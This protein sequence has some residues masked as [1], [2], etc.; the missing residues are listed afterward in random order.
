MF[1]EETLLEQVDRQI[2]KHLRQDAHVDKNLASPDS[3][4][5]RVIA[6]QAGVHTANMFPQTS[7]R[8]SA[9]R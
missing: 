7:T 8:I 5:K 4:V 2:G 9:Q 3:P 1:S 6:Y